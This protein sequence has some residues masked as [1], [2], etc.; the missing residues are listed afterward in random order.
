MFTQNLAK[1]LVQNHLSVLSIPTQHFQLKLKYDIELACVGRIIF[2][3]H[4]LRVESP[5]VGV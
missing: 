1:C 5:S 3:Q 2:K 4:A